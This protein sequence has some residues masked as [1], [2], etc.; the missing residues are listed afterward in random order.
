MAYKAV[1]GGLRESEKPCRARKRI[2]EPLP[3]LIFQQGIDVRSIRQ[4]T[5]EGTMK[6][7]DFAL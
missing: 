7:W 4:Q 3:A 2:T 1:V 5:D 6:R